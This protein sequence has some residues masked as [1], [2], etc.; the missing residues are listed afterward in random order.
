MSV[1]F[2]KPHW[3]ERLLIEAKLNLKEVGNLHMFCMCNCEKLI[4]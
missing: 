4:Q 2:P 3:S 1:E